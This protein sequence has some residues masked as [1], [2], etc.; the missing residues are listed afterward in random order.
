MANRLPEA[1]IVANQVLE[2]DPANG[3]ALFVAGLSALRNQHFKEAVRN[4]TWAV[5]AHPELKPAWVALAASYQQDKQLYRGESEIGQL[6]QTLPNAEAGWLVLGKLRTQAGDQP[7]ALNA[8]S[9]AA[10]LNTQDVDLWNSI[11]VAQ[12]RSKQVDKAETAFHKAIALSPQNAEAWNNLGAAYLQDGSLDKAEDAFKRA[13][14]ANPK[15]TEPMVN[16]IR[17]FIKE[18]R[19]DLA[20]QTCDSLA[21][22]DLKIADETRAEIP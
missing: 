9:K 2:L 16:L 12:A 5:Q 8:F 1:Q 21:A 11:G 4:L 19:L 13:H 6:L 7:G 3:A 22:I 10:A 17:T 14:D 15:L 20:R 18:G